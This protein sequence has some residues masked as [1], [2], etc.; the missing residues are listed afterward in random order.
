MRPAELRVH[1]RQLCCLGV[2]GEQ[3]MPPLLKAV[4]QL[5]GAESAAFFWVDADGDMTSLYAERL[6]PAPVM[7]LYFE[8]FYDAGE[9]SFKRAFAQR[10]RATD[11]VVAVSASTDAERT[12]YYNEVMRH[13]DAHHVLYG[14]VREQGRALGQLSLYRPKTARTFGS[15]ER[16]ELAAIM[17]YVAHGVSQR[18]RVEAANDALVDSADDAIVIVGA[19]GEVRQLAASAQKLLAL[20]THGRIGPAEGLA[21]TGDAARPVLR[22][23]VAALRDARAGAD[24]APPSLAVDNAWGRFVLRAYALSD[25]PV[26]GDALVAVRIQRQEPMLLR[27]VDALAGLGLSPQQRE[28]A[29]GLARGASNQEL[30]ES[31]GVSANTVAYHIKQLF[32]RLDTH[33]RQQMVG[34]VLAGTRP[35]G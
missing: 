23:L 7:Q 32:A 22:Q 11:P 29:A 5:V 16:D 35:D 24:V 9:S 12:A 6:L 27:F 17:R 15:G 13:L 21:G 30:A 10:A 31:L 25:G 33:D 18:P 19:D 8:R 28:I 1:I 20:A 2:T 4:R 34:R 3:L 26:E 14:I